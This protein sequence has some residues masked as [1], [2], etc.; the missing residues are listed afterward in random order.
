MDRPLFSNQAMAAQLMIGAFTQICRDPS[1]D[2]RR[3]L[4]MKQEDSAPL[5]R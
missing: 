5:N 4:T 2:Y 3:E 1:N